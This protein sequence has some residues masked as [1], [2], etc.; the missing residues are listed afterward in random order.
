MPQLQVNARTIADLTDGQA[1]AVINSAI[2]KAI[3]DLD[4]RGDEDGK[5]RVVV[6]ELRMAN[7]K[8]ITTVEVVAAAKLPPFR[9]HA[10]ACKKAHRAGGGVALTFQGFNSENPDQPTFAEMEDALPAPAGEDDADD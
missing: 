8:S 6:I 1:E 9:T 3:S 10:T 7:V 4:D 2:N 5:E